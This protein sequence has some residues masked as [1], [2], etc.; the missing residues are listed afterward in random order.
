MMRIRK[1]YFGLSYICVICVYLRPISAIFFILHCA[2][3][4]VNFYEVVPTEELDPAHRASAALVSPVKD[5][6]VK[7]PVA[8][9]THLAL[10]QFVVPAAVL[11]VK[12]A[13]V[14]DTLPLSFLLC[15]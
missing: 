9:R 5:P 3:C 4:I 13:A 11:E 14:L 7:V 8:K 10:D 12:L 6:P 15:R 2:L 1:I